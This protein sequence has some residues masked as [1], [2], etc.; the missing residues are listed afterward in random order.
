MAEIYSHSKLSAFE[1][2]K[3]KYKYRYIDKIVPE[4]EQTI[5]SHLGKMVHNSLEWLYIRVREKIIPTLDEVIMYYSKDWQDKFKPEF[6]IVKQ[7]L[8]AENYFNK[9]IEFLINY[10]T[11]HQ[12]FDDNTLELEKKI[13]FD[14]D[15]EGKYCIMGFIDRLVYNLEKERYE[16]HDYK[17][18]ASMP[19]QEDIDT[20]RQ[21][22]FY[23]ISIKELNGYDEEVIL[24]WHYL[25][26]NKKVE[27]ARTNDQ[28]SQLKQETIN[29]IEEIQNTTQFPPNKSVLCDWCEYKSMCPAWGN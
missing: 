10:Y 5:E 12:P 27:S 26:H 18:S 14:L 16:V 7:E 28:L 23:A 8:T 19:R 22:A 29:L 21:L 15:A 25:A 13:I 24:V 2:C 17:T 4:V 1:Q 6:V 9:G 3:L 20:D 11:K